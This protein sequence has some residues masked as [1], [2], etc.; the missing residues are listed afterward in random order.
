ME[1]AAVRQGLHHAQIGVG[2]FHILAH[3]RH[4]HAVR[5]GELAFDHSGPFGQ[6]AWSLRQ[7]QHLNH[8][9]VQPLAVQQQRHLVKA[10][11]VEVLK[12]TVHRQVAEHG[13]FGAHVIRQ[14]MIGTAHQDVR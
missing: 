8:L 3:Q 13:D 5:T 4:T 9:L 11:G 14:L 10:A 6:I 1:N 12:D 2:K 7:A